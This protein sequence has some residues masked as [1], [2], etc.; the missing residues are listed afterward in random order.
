MTLMY[1]TTHATIGLL[2]AR[3][4]PNPV[5]AF[6]LGFISHY[7]LDFIPHDNLIKDPKLKEK[8]RKE[9]VDIK[10][11]P[12]YR[13]FIIMAII[14]H[15]I[16]IGLFIFLFIY[17][18]QMVQ[19]PISAI[20]AMAGAI[21]PDYLWAPYTMWKWKIFKPF[22]K[23]NLW[24]HS[25]RKDMVPTWLGTTLQIVFVVVILTLIYFY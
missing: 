11:I 21:I 19:N 23:L 17:Q 2:I 1:I 13:H 6:I 15:I 18:E 8:V 10:K 3:V 22:H 14:D 24:V 12:A 25:L 9:E 20:T 4:I 7:I 5:L 16:I